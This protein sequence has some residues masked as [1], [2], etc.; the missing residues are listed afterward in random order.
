MTHKSLHFPGVTKG[1]DFEWI[2]TLT[3]KRERL[4]YITKF[5][6]YPIAL[7]PSQMIGERHFAFVAVSLSLWITST[8]AS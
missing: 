5:F 4:L 1:N 6:L 7:T 3:I 8:F 2:L